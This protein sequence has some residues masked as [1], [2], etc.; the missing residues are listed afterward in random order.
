M[1][2]LWKPISVLNQN[3]SSVK[4]PLESELTERVIR[5]LLFCI[6][7][8]PDT[9]GVQ[10]I[11]FPGQL[12][13]PGIDQCCPTRFEHRSETSRLLPFSFLIVS[14]K[15]RFRPTEGLISG[16]LSRTMA[17]RTPRTRNF[18]QSHLCT[19]FSRNR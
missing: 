19:P 1:E 3:Q 7:L 14:I 10:D 8:K 2:L 9:Q 6:W 13:L 12:Y 5:L 4:H 15:H 18:N 17:E 16:S 11:T